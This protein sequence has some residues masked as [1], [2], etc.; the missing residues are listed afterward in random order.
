MKTHSLQE[1]V[2]ICNESSLKRMCKHPLFVKDVLSVKAIIK[3]LA[4]A[5]KW[6]LQFTDAINFLNTKDAT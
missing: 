6:T 5:L 1:M 4:E 2:A 3:E